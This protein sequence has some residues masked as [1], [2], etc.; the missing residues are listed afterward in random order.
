MNQS[1]SPIIYDGFSLHDDGP[2]SSIYRNQPEAKHSRL[3]APLEQQSMQTCKEVCLSGWVH[4]RHDSHA[5]PCSDHHDT[6]SW[7]GGPG[8]PIGVRP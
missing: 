4:D 8:L 1:L 7:P 5:T 6:R 3:R 2:A